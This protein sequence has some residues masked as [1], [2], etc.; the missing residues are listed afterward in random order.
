MLDVG[1]VCAVAAK[2]N[3]VTLPLVIV[4]AWVWGLKV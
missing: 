3:P 4:A 2:F 1:P